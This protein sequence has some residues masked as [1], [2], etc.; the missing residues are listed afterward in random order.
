MHELSVCLSLLR[1]VENIARQHDAAT[2]DQV[3]LKVG[4]L[5]GVEPELLR[6][7][8]PLAV[9]GTV[10][11]K[12]ELFIEYGEIIV[13]CTEC[14]AESP[15]KTNRLLCAACGDFRTR[16]VSGDEMILERIELTPRR[17]VAGDVLTSAG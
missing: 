10:A 6:K 4:P 8:Y 14:G 15:A 7:A 16:L 17:P 2:V 3:F 5:S 1:Q 9:A 13:A 12:A 11:E